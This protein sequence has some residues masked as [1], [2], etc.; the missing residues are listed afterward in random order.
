MS[1]QW[2]RLMFHGS[3]LALLNNPNLMLKIFSRFFFSFIGTYRVSREIAQT[4]D[5]AAIHLL[6][7][8][9]ID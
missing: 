9:F 2:I 8:S 7:D 6:V 5:C 4:H 1:D 3:N